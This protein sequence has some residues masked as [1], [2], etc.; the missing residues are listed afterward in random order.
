MSR[1]EKIK[2]ISLVVGLLLLCGGLG[3][4]LLADK[5]EWKRTKV[6]LGFGREAQLNDY[7]AASKFLKRLG[8]ESDWTVKRKLIANLATPHTQPGD[9][10]SEFDLGARDTLVMMD[11]RAAFSNK[12]LLALWNWVEHGGVLVYSAQNPYVGDEASRDFVLSKLGLTVTEDLSEKEKA[13][14]AKKQKEK[15]P[16]EKDL[17]AN[18]GS[19]AD[20][21]KQENGNDNNANPDNA[22]SDETEDEDAAANSDEFEPATVPCIPTDYELQMNDQAKSFKLNIRPAPYMYLS[23]SEFH[24]DGIVYQGDRVLLATYRIGAGKIVIATTAN[25]WDN[26][27]ISCH[28]H[29]YFLSSLVNPNSKVWFFRNI[30]SPSLGAVIWRAAPFTVII[31]LLALLFWLWSRARRFGPTLHYSTTERRSFSEHLLASA[32]FLLIHR[33]QDLIVKQLRAEL[34]QRLQLKHPQY[35]RLEHRERLQL[36]SSLSGLNVEEVDAAVFKPLSDANPEF[37]R[38]VHLLKIIREN[39]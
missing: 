24:P 27:H 13:E 16:T 14:I 12:Y 15:D 39:T 38:I 11:S 10:K 19:P 32:R 7:L 25:W 36:L 30:D 6:D 21:Q 34:T 5:F 37:V 28:D 23:D 1:A 2:V 26:K 29:A 31:S 8:I 33:K 35:R 18:E 22:N 20:D 4:W 3:Y 9:E 17:D